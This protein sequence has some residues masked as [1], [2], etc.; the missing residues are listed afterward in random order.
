MSVQEVDIEKS[1]GLDLLSPAD[2]IGTSEC[3]ERSGSSD[4]GLE[5]GASQGEETL[6]RLKSSLL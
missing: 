3:K 6:Q 5:A 1:A 2:T 4:A